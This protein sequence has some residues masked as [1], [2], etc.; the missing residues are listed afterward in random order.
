MIKIKIILG[1]IRPNRFSEKAGAWIL[2][3]VRERK[4][5]DVELLDLR[6]YPLPLFNE[7]I[8]PSMIKDGDYANE[9]ARRWSEK[10]G[11]ADGFIIVTPEYNHSMPGLLK[12]AFDYVYAEWNK[13]PIG[14][15]AYG[16]VGG[17][18]AVEHLREVTVELQMAP[19]RNSVH[20]PQ[21]WNLLD[22]NGNL[23]AGSL[24][25]F[26]KGADALLDQLIWWAVALK[27]A[28]AQ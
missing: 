8:S 22:E 1:S 19:I 16:T 6:D 15:V 2:K 20:I 28:R 27:S 23:K 25:V 14:F 11:E 24:E 5:I 21:H 3:R 7:L 10:I 18:R 12:N 4:E 17:A 13:K 9:V 26:N